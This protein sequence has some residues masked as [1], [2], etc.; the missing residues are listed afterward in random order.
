MPGSERKPT[1]RQAGSVSCGS[2]RITELELG[3][4]C[5]VKMIKTILVMHFKATV[6]WDLLIIFWVEG[7]KGFISNRVRLGRGRG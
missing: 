3:F 2:L 7:G 6:G 1:P 4:S 5:S